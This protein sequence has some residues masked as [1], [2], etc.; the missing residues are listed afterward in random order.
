M[1][2]I[3]FTIFGLLFVLQMALSQQQPGNQ[4]AQSGLQAVPQPQSVASNNEQVRRKRNMVSGGIG[5]GSTPSTTTV[6]GR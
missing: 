5:G 4:P 2:F 6:G 1:K 3:L